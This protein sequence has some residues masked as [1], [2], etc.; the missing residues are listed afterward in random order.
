MTT[1]R[2][3]RKRS[4]ARATRGG[5]ALFVVAVT[6]G[7]LAAMGVYGLS[8]TAVDIRSAGH[9]REAAQGQAA[10]EHAL[11][12]T[13]ETFTPATT[14]ELVRAMQST[15]IQSTSCR[16]ANAYDSA[17][18]AEFRAAQACVSLNTP[19]MYAISKNV[20][21]W[22]SGNETSTFTAE[23]FGKVSRRAEVRVEVTNPVEM[24][25]PP[26]TGLNDR[27]VFSQLTVT[28]F[29]DMKAT[30]TGNTESTVQGRGRITV[31]P[32]FR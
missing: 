15:G 14:G 10:A 11:I 3:A 21:A 23:S 2:L 1:A 18:N 24:P 16:S 9:L 4:K 28:T 30:G 13:A 22:T 20:N 19:Q 12:L 8:A 27:Y 6:L 29:V 25:P 17:N 26:G 31:G 32:Y 5:A 7:L